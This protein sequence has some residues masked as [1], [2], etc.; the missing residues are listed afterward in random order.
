MAERV[1]ITS[2]RR[3][4]TRPTD[5]SLG[6]ELREQTG[7]GD[8]YLRGLMSAQLR[9][10]ATVLAVG[11]LLLVGLPLVFALVPATRDITLAGIPLPWLVLG[12]AVYPAAL[13]TARFYVRASERIEREL[14]D[15][16]AQPDPPGAG[17][18]GP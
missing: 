2:S 16:S 10:S 18:G 8:V 7:L 11:A 12:V 3:G 6:H 1:R 15:V 14:R 4:A 5:R 13:V 17:G 9:L